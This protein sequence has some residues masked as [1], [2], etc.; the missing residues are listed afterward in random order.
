MNVNEINEIFFGGP[1]ALE[2][3]ICRQIYE[4]EQLILISGCDVAEEM[5][6]KGIKA[7]YGNTSNTNFTAAHKIIDEC[8]AKNHIA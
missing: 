3:P 4:R 8:D 1:Q 5:K 6:W 7:R 2:T